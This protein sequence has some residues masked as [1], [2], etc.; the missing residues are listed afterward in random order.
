MIQSRLFESRRS[1]NRSLAPRRQQ[2]Y[3]Y[4]SEAG[5]SG[6]F[7]SLPL[8][9]ENPGGSEEWEGTLGALGVSTRRGV[10]MAAAE[11]LDKQDGRQ[12]ER[13]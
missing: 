7:S 4:K 5:G 10:N 9:G 6:R 11:M 1:S 12:E 13:E 3:D 8:L 2:K